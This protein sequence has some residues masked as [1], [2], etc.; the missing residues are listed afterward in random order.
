MHL[1]SNPERVGRDLLMSHEAAWYMA[2]VIQ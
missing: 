2:I 1:K